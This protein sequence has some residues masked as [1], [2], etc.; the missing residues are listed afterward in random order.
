MQFKIERASSFD[1]KVR[2]CEGATEQRHYYSDGEGYWSEWFIEI[3]TLDDLIKLGDKCGYE[4]IIDT[5]DKEILIYD[6]YIE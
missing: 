4:L 2:P 1:S 3:N 6:N 5:E